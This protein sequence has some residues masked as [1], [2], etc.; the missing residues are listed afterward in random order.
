MSFMSENVSVIFFGVISY[1]GGTYKC[2]RPFLQ[3]TVYT[4]V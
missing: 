1:V 2:I 4:R 3:F